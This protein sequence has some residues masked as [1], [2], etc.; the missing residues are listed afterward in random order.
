[1]LTRSLTMAMQDLNPQQSAAVMHRGSPCLIKALAGSGKTKVLTCRA[2]KLLLIDDVPLNRVLLVTFTKKAAAEMTRRLALILEIPEP[3][4]RKAEMHIG[5]FHHTASRILRQY[6]KEIG[7]EPN[8]TILDEDETE[9]LAKSIFKELQ[10]KK[11][12]FSPNNPLHSPGRFLEQHS[13]IINECRDPLLEL[14]ELA[15]PIGKDAAEKAVLLYREKKREHNVVDYDD[16]L[17]LWKTLTENPRTGGEIGTLW[18]HVLIDE[19]QDTNKLQESIITLLN[20]SELCVVGDYH[21]SIYGFR[22]ADPQNFSRFVDRY[23]GAVVFPLE[24]NYRS[25]PQILNSANEIL[26]DTGETN[27][28]KAVRQSGI[29]TSF[30]AYYKEWDEADAIAREIQRAI[31]S[32]VPANEICVLART[33][34]IP[35]MVEHKLNEYGIPYEKRGGTKI[36]NRKEI[37]HCVAF[38]RLLLNPLDFAAW[39]TGLRLY[40]RIGQ[41]KANKVFLA[42]KELI[43]KHNGSI[44]AA[45]KSGDMAQLLAEVDENQQGVGRLIA[46]AVEFHQCE[47]RPLKDYIDRIHEEW[48]FLAPINYEKHN[49][50]ERCELVAKEMA[51]WKSAKNLIDLVERMSL[52]K[53]EEEERLQQEIAHG[54]LRV[55]IS[56]IHSAKGLEWQKVIFMGVGCLQIP[57]PMTHTDAEQEEERRLV[58]VAITRARDTLLLT[59]PRYLQRTDGQKAEQSASP[60]LHKTFQQMR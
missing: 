37:K 4:L 36:T 1:M 50:Q 51:Y 30:F 60:I 15:G 26:Q 22:A 57:S 47:T 23:P 16:L 35:S 34:R 8:F 55:V 20:T 46:L 2:A 14:P 9:Y 19:Y 24:T 31:Q 42:W 3:D 5:T 21:Q 48:Q 18:D 33:S 41:A 58:Y 40:P 10:L 38:A 6:G 59:Y 52:S 17:D 28:L 44:Q 25:T 53:A 13:R 54:N 49:L 27:R 43:E 12:E 45:I 11:G 56:T 39:A 7:L 29:E 32:G